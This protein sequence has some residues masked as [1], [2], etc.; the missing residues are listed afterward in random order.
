MIVRG[1]P[2]VSDEAPFESGAGKD[3]S[4]PDLQAA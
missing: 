1:S 2:I 3:Q 4:N